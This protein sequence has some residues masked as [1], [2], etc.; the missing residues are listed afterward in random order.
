MFLPFL[1]RSGGQRF[2]HLSPGG[3]HFLLG[4]VLK[5]PGGATLKNIMEDTGWAILKKLMR[6]WVAAASLVLLLNAV[7]GEVRIQVDVEAAGRY[8]FRVV[9]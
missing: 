6:N 1:D 5:R 7:P 9:V 8:R 3:H 2:Q 4:P